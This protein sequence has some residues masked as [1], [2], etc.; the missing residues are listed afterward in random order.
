MTKLNQYRVCPTVQKIKRKFSSDKEFKLPYAN[1]KD[2]N[3]IIKSLDVYKAKGSDW[4]SAKFDKMSTDITDFHIANI[5]NKG[6]SENTYSENAK[7]AH[8]RLIF[9]KGDKT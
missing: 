8:V 7:T 4:I 9:K 1:A 5:I 3:Q 2:I 6:I